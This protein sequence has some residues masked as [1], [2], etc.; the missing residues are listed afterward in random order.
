MNPLILDWAAAAEAGAAIAGG[1][2]WQLGCMAQFG[3]PVPPGFVISAAASAGRRSGDPLPPDLAA[4]IEQELARRGWQEQPLAVR[5]SAPSEDSSRASFAGIHRS[6]LN[7]R[8]AAA[9]VQAV[10][11]VCDSLWSAHAQAYRSRS[12]IEDSDGAM[13]VVVMPLLPALASGIAFTRDPVSGRDDHILIHAHW[14]LGESLVAGQA[15][16]DEY[17]LQENY[18]DLSLSVLEQRLGAK[19]RHTVTNGEHGTELRNTAQDK[20]AQMVLTEGQA[21]ELGAIVRDAAQ[22]L[23]YAASGYDLE[24]VWDGARFWIVQARPISASTYLTYPALAGQCNH[25]TRGNTQEVTP[26]PLSPIEWALARAVINRMLASGYELSGYRP[27][28]GVQRAGLFHGRLYL[29]SSI[30]QW[31]AFDALGIPPA[32]LNQLVG[33][34]QPEIEVPAATA[35]DKLRHLG[36]MLR[37][38]RNSPRARRRGETALRTA[39]QRAVDW[40]VRELPAS[41]AG[42]ARQLREQLSSMH[43]AEDLFFL[44][45]SGGGTLYS[46]AQ[47]IDKH[48]PGE[49]HALTAGL[50]AGGTPSVTAAQGYALLEL[51]G[52]AA[53]DSH[54]MAWLTR[55]GRRSADWA[56][57]LPP[58]SPFL[59]AFKNFLEQYGHRGIYETYLRNPRWREQPGYLFDSIVRLIG[60][61]PQAM[62]A[63]QEKLSAEAWARVRGTMPFWMWPVLKKLVNNAT[64][65]CNQREAARSAI[66]AGSEVFR[67]WLLALGARFAHPGGLDRPEDIF[68]LTLLEVF[69][70][71]EDRLAPAA[72]ARR[73][74]ARARQLALWSADKEPDV[75]IERGSAVQAAPL[76]R[77]GGAE[78]RWQGTSVA[79]GRAAGTACIARRPEDGA[80][81]ADG[82]VL[83]VPSTDPSWTPLF[84]SAGALVMETGGYLSHGAI[85][86]REFGIPAVVNLPGILDQL[87]DGE[88]LEVD[89]GKGTVRR[90]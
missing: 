1:K 77:E 78:G 45:G 67:R 89:G 59:H 37:Y 43:Q 83:V 71:A 38:L 64:K 2:G 82:D 61:P 57:E 62:Q 51:A 11:A 31:E 7:V 69:D 55:P 42:L 32:A 58:D 41:S 35:R 22:A 40:R 5:S 39:R 79:G 34:R 26:D 72:A 47:M 65:E 9:T 6:C 63:R 84:L 15:D 90:V 56:R 85:V 16:G 46:L 10:E 17:R 48:F 70:L 8:G 44:Q 19:A 76:A 49:G 30:L 80:G 18:V 3:V 20:R 52:V 36:R 88:R 12:G 60:A 27:L 68:N 33:G 14:G 4:A 75:I 25:W 86:A 74:A 24:W 28:P 50:M 29:E 81:M 66:T 73:A 53:N 87:A 23:D 13:A 54:A 21:L